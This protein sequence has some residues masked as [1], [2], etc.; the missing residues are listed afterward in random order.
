MLH[1]LWMFLPVC[2]HSVAFGVLF[3]CLLP[4]HQFPLPLRF[5]PFHAVTDVRGPVVLCSWVCAFSCKGRAPPSGRGL[6]NSPSQARASH[7]RGRGDG[8]APRVRGR[9]GA[10]E[11][12][13]GAGLTPWLCRPRRPPSRSAD[14]LTV[15]GNLVGCSEGQIGKYTSST[16]QHLASRQHRGSVAAES[17]VVTVGRDT[18]GL[19]RTIAIGVS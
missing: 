10:L 1:S 14:L 17:L 4:V 13:R 15:G 19:L 11:G 5:M 16:H 8:P 6:A 3:C 9:A 18:V 2:H 12:P 7:P